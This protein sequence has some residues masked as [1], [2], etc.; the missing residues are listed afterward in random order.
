[1][2]QIKFKSKPKT[3]IR[4]GR[5]MP[6]NADLESNILGAL[7]IDKNCVPEGMKELSKEFFYLDKHQ[8]VFESIRF[9]FDNFQGVDILSLTNELI[10][11]GKL[12]QVGGAFEVVKLTN[13]VIS[14]N[15]L[16]TW[17]GY[18]KDFFLQRRAIEIGHNLIHEGFETDSVSDLLTGTSNEI[19]KT[20]ESIFVS[21]QKT[22]GDFLFALAKERD[23][24]GR[25]GVLG[26]DTGFQI[27]NKYVSGWVR[28]DLIIIAARPSQGKTAFMINSLLNCVR[29]GIPVGVF[30]L[31]MSGE[32]I[33]NRILSIE[34]GIDHARLRNAKLTELDQK[35]ITFAEN[36]ISKFP[37]HIEDNPA[38][39][40]RELRAKATIMK[41]KFGIQ[42]LFVDYLQL[43]SGVDRKQNRESEIA[44]I[45][46]G[47]KII[48][49]E[50]EIPVIALSQLSRA[51]ESRPD[52][53]PQL[54]DLRESGGI[55]QDADCVLFLMRPETYQIPE[56]EFEG[57][58]MSSRGVA[59]IKIA[60]NRH[61]S[62]TN[63]PLKFSG[64]TMTFE[65]M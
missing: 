42:I 36:R 64:E 40:I 32:Q 19:L 52:K 26:L 7:L 59:I 15:H 53:M 45:S 35:T 47:C 27:L 5:V 65:N 14:G 23:E 9:L 8:I 25:S 60:K 62:L 12:E 1:M 3:D 48:A 30:S 11:R 34:T 41:R 13:D 63:F 44:E 43:M 46:R 10:K 18:L 16:K 20:Q 2:Q 56:I 57:Q 33:V 31:E 55:E 37:I 24:V 29:N 6:Y 21:L 54:S 49:K 38:L 51:V 22:I 58:T 61:G 4:F 50:L 17:I 39:N 28:P